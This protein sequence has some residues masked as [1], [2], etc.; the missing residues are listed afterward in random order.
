MGDWQRAGRPVFESLL[1]RVQS[2]NFE[3][4]FTVNFSS[5]FRCQTP[6]CAKDEVF[7]PAWNNRQNYGSAAVLWLRLKKYWRTLRCCWAGRTQILC[8]LQ[9]GASTSFHAAARPRIAR[10][11]ALHS[12]QTKQ[13]TVTKQAR[14]SIRSSGRQSLKVTCLVGCFAV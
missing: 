3:T 6:S 7:T 13:T 4:D 12:V 8:S 11:F 9:L 10:H 5:A 2:A 14:R 1:R